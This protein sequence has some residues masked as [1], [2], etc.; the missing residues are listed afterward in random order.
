L[1]FTVLSKAAFH[2]KIFVPETKYTSD[3]ALKAYFNMGNT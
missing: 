2:A 3:E 1:Y